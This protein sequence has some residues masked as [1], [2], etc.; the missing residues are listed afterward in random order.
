M[1]LET[2]LFNENIFSSPK[3]DFGPYFRFKS[4]FDA[5]FKHPKFMT[6]V[7]GANKTSVTKRK[8]TAVGT[9]MV[10]TVRQ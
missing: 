1:R 4:A 6:E 3:E 10:K 8:P 2:S 7:D 9:V 5:F